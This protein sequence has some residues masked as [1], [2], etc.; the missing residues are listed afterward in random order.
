MLNF[1]Y[2]DAL[3]FNCIWLYNATCGWSFHWHAAI[4]LYTSQLRT[5]Q[6]RRRIFNIGTLP[7]CIPANKQTN[8]SGLLTCSV[9]ILMSGAVYSV[10]CQDTWYKRITPDYQQSYWQHQYWVQ[11]TRP[12]S[13]RKWHSRRSGMGQTGTD[14]SK[15]KKVF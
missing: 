1:K 5:T 3:R 7:L 8:M 12:S 6:R 9:S 11:E 15:K 4:A 2:Q 14:R 10:S 13:E